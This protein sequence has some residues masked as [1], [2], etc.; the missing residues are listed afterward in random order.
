MI[1]TWLV[2]ASISLLLAALAVAARRLSAHCGQ[3]AA[4]RLGLATTTVLGLV[5]LPFGLLAVYLAACFALGQPAPESR[6]L[7]PGVTYTRLVRS[8]PRPIVA[9][10]VVVDLDRGSRLA[11]TP[12]TMTPDGPRAA[13][14]TPT[15]ALEALD[16]DLAIN[17]SF[18][19]PFRES[20]PLSFSP[21]EGDLVQPIG[22]TIGE[23]Q[24]FGTPQPAWI[25]FW[26]TPSGEAGFGPPPPEASL[27]VSGPRWLLR[28]DEPIPP[29]SNEPIPPGSNEPIPPGSN[30]PIPPG[31][32]EPIPPGSNEP[33]PP[34]SNEPIPPGSNEPIPGSESH[35]YPHTALGLDLAR[36]RLVLIVVDGKQPRYSLGMTDREL[37][38]LFLELGV[39]EAIELDGG[40]SSAL[41]GRGL[42]G[43]PA[44]LS[45]PCH[46]KIP[47]CQRPVANILGVRFAGTPGRGTRRPR[48]KESP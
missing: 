2:S 43:S 26:A 30:E 42:D 34:G 28:R 18:F 48:G 4:A 7:A 39:A 46:T 1:L 5:S 10:V 23:G 47:R 38:Q 19:H 24:P 9:H 36:R 32:N 12:P 15:R 22:P 8:S 31:S 27:A 20:H 35:P 17:A 21:H 41:A 3:C 29:G 13:A 44:L 33:I 37:A 16:V 14:L 11:A 45:R 25:T 40:G 6:V